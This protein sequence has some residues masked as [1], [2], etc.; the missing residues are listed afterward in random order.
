MF[1]CHSTRKTLILNNNLWTI[2][3]PIHHMSW[4]CWYHILRFYPL[5]TATRKTGSIRWFTFSQGHQT[6]ISCKKNLLPNG[7]SAFTSFLSSDWQS[8]HFT[9]LARRGNLRSTTP[10]ASCRSTSSTRRSTSS[11]GSGCSS[12]ARSPLS[13]SSTGWLSASPPPSAPTSSS[14]ATASGFFPNQ[15]IK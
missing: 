12:W 13:W 1:S 2:Y 10:S 4:C 3:L 15:D 14:C 9:N 5:L 11:S 8:A 6:F 7:Q